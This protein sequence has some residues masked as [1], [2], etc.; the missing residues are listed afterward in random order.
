MYA[1]A[2]FLFF[3]YFHRREWKILPL[4]ILGP[5]VWIGSSTA[6]SG[7]VSTFFREWSR[8]SS[9]GKFIPGASLTHYFSSLHEIFGFA[10]VV[11]FASGVLYIARAEK[12][13]DYGILYI[14]IAY[15]IVFNTIAGAEIF[16]WTGSI[17]ELRYIAVVG[18]FFG[19]VAVYGF[20]EIYEKARTPI[21][22]IALSAA[23]FGIVVFQCTLTNH[24]RRWPNY[25]QVVINMTRV[26]RAEHPD[27]TLLSN[28]SAAAFVMDVAPS[29]GPHYAKFNKDRLERHPECLILWDPFTSNSLFFQTELTKERMLQD[30]TVVVLDRY[31]Y[32][33]AE[34]LLLYRN[35]NR[36]Q[37][38]NER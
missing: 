31:K 6:I 10:Q 38:K 35:I 34:Y 37:L 24:P 5:L 33:R 22:Q 4:V 11:L 28:N 3:I 2:V 7:D 12:S 8:F 25:D 26:L 32:W 16:H 29:G 23:V 18:P 14:T 27:L 13:A 15:V 30:T 36:T 21:K 19:I 17:G 9:L 1:F 20:S